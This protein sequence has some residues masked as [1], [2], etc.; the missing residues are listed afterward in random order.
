MGDL[1]RS[2]FSGVLYTGIA[3]Y[4]GIIIS[5][6]VTAILARLI[7]VED[8]G[9]VAIATILVNFFSTLTTVG[10]SPAIVQNKTITDDELKSINSF[11]FVIAIV[12][13]LLYTL[14]IPLILS[15]YDNN[16]KLQPVLYLLVINIFFSI[17]A[18]VPNAMILKDKL[19]KFIAQ[20][21]LFI[22]L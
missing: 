2:F 14:L 19:F 3:K 13:C 11:S 22:Q 16:E 17:A 21:T 12:V 18:V 4:S 1:K 7:S 8:F 6:V 5:I 20:R 15:Y 10:I 9:I